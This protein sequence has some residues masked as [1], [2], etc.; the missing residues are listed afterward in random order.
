[1]IGIGVDLGGTKIEAL[2]VD[3]KRSEL[4][5]D[6][7][8]TPTGGYREV[9]EA[10][11][12]LVVSLEKRVGQTAPRIGIGTPGAISP[13]TGQLKNSNSTA[14]NG[15]KL[16]TDLA[17]ALQR[18]LVMA[19]DADC[20]AL[21]E[22]RNGA[23]VGYSSVFGVILGTGVGGGIAIN[24][25]L[26]DG[27]NRLVGE[28]GNNPLPWP[29]PEEIPGPQ[30]YCGQFGCVEKWVSGPGFSAD[31]ERRSGELLTPPEIIRRME[32]GDEQAQ[33]SFDMYVDRLSRSLA[34]VVNILDPEVIVLGGGMSNIA[35]LYQEVTNRWAR[36][37]FGGECLTKLLPNQLG[38]S[39]GVWGAV[40]LSWTDDVTPIVP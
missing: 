13:Q 39:A 10:V 9:I 15:Q 1:M 7:V 30:C 28:W 12:E 3:D 21:A 22:T 19:N 2:A 4:A 37:M 33:T 16:D 14:L 17:A 36:Y 29:Q 25:Q 40:H 26:L 24:G 11:T 31:H 27:P 35:A 23:G 6:R 32:A 20:F 38:D 5:R 34:V 18:P 8:P